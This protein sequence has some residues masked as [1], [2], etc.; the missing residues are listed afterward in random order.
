MITAIAALVMIA[1][2]MFGKSMLNW[3]NGIWTNM[4]GAGSGPKIQKDS[5]PVPSS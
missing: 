3:L 4:V 5:L 1:M 2:Y